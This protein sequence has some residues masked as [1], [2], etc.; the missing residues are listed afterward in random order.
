MFCIEEDISSKESTCNRIPSKSDCEW[1]WMIYTWLRII[2]IQTF[3]AELHL[4]W[5]SNNI[6]HI[7]LSPTW[8]RQRHSC[9]DAEIIYSPK[10]ILQAECIITGANGQ[11]CSKRNATA[12]QQNKGFLLQSE[13]AS[14]QFR[15][16][17]SMK[18]ME[19]N[20]KAMNWGNLIKKMIKW[21]EISQT[22]MEILTLVSISN[23]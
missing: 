8:T 15:S 16:H 7:E 12:K 17:N 18:I 13:A 2:W 19:I 1:D 4:F 3:W 14:F 10:I 9:H 6:S 11:H 5:L 22:F 20:L 21:W 23:F